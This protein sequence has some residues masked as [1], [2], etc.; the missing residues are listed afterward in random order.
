LRQPLL[1]DNILSKHLLF[2]Y[3]V[4]FFI[5][6]YNPFVVLQPFFLKYN[7]TFLN[8]N[9]HMK[10]IQIIFI[11]LLFFKI[12][13]CQIV[14]VR[15]VVSSTGND[16]L[17]GNTTWNYTVGE[18]VVNTAT[19]G[20]NVITQGFNQPDGYYITPLFPS[21][22]SF[23]IYPNPGK[24]NSQLRF[25]L[26]ADKPSLT[27]KIFDAGGQLYSTQV[28]ESFAGQTWHS[29]NPQIM[30][31]GTYIVKV[32]VGDQVFSGKYIVIN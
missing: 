15:Q 1:I 8:K 32:Y 7:F 26:H 31:A 18:A 13:V 5:S 20:N 6:L 10:K 2:Y 19:I 3:K 30:A 22:S 29:L 4:F 12:S 23:L 25:Y 24:P 21:A 17:I 9:K 27:V 14:P 11:L 16:T 28:L